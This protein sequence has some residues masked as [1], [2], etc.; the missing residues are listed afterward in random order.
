MAQLRCQLSEAETG[1]PVQWLKEGVELHGSPK[2]EI[3]RLG[4]TCEL[5]IHGLEAK[6]TGEYVCVAGGQKTVASVMVKGE[7]FLPHPLPR[8]LPWG[9]TWPGPAPIKAKPLSGRCSEG[10]GVIG[11]VFSFP[12]HA[13]AGAPREEC[14]Q[15]ETRCNPQHCPA[16]HPRP[17]GAL[18]CL[19]G[20][21]SRLSWPGQGW[22]QGGDGQRQPSTPQVL[23]FLPNRGAPSPVCAP[24]SRVSWWQMGGAHRGWGKRRL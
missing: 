5:L 1:V 23:T 14:S 3:R 6:D 15:W 21:A 24:R 20:L 19:K 10:P 17:S 12:L 22:P 4:T 11:S 7:P 13:G 8:W 2:Y 18:A 16:S 9:C